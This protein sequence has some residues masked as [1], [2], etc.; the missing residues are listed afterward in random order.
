LKASQS[1]GVA[2]SGISSRK[3]V[4]RSELGEQLTGWPP[5]SP[6]SG[7][8]DRLVL[9]EYLRKIHN[10]NIIRYS[11]IANMHQKVTIYEVPK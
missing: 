3:P 11:R 9:L 10:Y 7:L 4:I 8:R 1:A 2:V 5:G 6:D